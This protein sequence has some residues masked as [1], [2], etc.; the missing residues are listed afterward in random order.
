MIAVHVKVDTAPLILRL[1]K[2]QRRLAYVVAN[3]LNN[4]ARDI[5]AAE[6]A[7]VGADL[8]IRKQDFIR[9][10]AAII[11]PFASPRLGR[12]FVDISV[13]Q[14]S[15]LLLSTFEQGGDRPP[16]KGQSVAVPI[17]GEAARPSFGESV[18]T[19]MRFTK[20]FG[21]R[22]R[23]RRGAER[24]YIVPGVGV[25]Q[26]NGAETNLIYSFEKNV[27][28]GKRLHFVATASRVAQERFR[29]HLEDETT[30]AVIWAGGRGL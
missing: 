4:T 2:G 14:K 18:P 5:Q 19:E 8:T 3:A 15:R 24:T 1:E 7:E 10:Q 17:T 27:R 28:V 16:F 9:R 21:G 29:S 6:R 26:R 12:A 11:K 23:D 22:K 20:L 30:K 25:F 13:G